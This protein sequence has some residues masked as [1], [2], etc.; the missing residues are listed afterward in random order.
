MIEL[1][2]MYTYEELVKRMEELAGKYPEYLSLQCAGISHDERE[3]PVLVLG[4]SGKCL[5]LSG[6]IHGRES[7]NP[8]LLLGMAED[9]CERRKRAG[10]QDETGRI[11]NKYSIYFL[12][13][14]NPD[15][16]EIALWGFE[17]IRNP[18]L[19]H[20]M[21]MKEIPHETWKY[22]A[23]GIDINR[24]FPC[25]S[26]T[27]RGNM[28]ESASE[29]ETK[30]LID[31]FAGYPD[32]VGYIDFH[33]RGRIIYYYRRAMPFFYNRRGKHMA[34]KF[35]QISNYAIGKKREEAASVLDGGNSVNYYSE[36]Y[37]KLAITVET[38]EDCAD[39]PLDVGY[40]E[41]TYQEVSEIPLSF[42]MEYDRG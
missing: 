23:R 25:R 36:N 19:R 34:K 31:I 1:G 38:V 2:H 26:Y 42:L 37:E 4:S 28:R 13:V 41:K 35:Q 6:G 11:L 14:A 30:A 22:N 21:R 29:N 9:Y 39:F 40:Y 32:S 10:E 20:T 15:G 27:S 16:Y 12:P 5:I 33:S 7:I 24:N 17:S 18:V 3:I 8:V